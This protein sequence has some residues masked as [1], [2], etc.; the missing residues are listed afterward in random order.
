MHGRLPLSPWIDLADLRRR[1]AV[2]VWEGAS[3]AE[4]NEWRATF[5]G[6][7]IQPPL[8]LARQ[9]LFPVRPSTV[10]YAFVPPRP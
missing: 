1:G 6:M 8:V 2:L 9:T 7:E 4:M 10:H 5:P 3:E